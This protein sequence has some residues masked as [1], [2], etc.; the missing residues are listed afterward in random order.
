MTFHDLHGNMGPE[1]AIHRAGNFAQRGRTS[2]P[3]GIRPMGI[4]RAPELESA[5][6]PK[7]ICISCVVQHCTPVQCKSLSK[8]GQSVHGL[9]AT[10]GGSRP[11]TSE[12][13]ASHGQSPGPTGQSC[14]DAITGDRARPHALR[15]TRYS[16]VQGLHA[17]QRHRPGRLTSSRETC[18]LTVVDRA[19]S[20]C[21]MRRAMYDGLHP[22]FCALDGCPTCPL[23]C[24]LSPE[25]H[26]RLGSSIPSDRAIALRRRYLVS[27]GLLS[28]PRELNRLY[29]RSES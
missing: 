25:S 16:G 4:S 3:E 11:V 19:A 2:R 1:C 7:C 17:A 5:T 13:S 28:A 14:G 24:P 21:C 18:E 22:A 12:Q 27:V 8:Y 20:W 9:E 23:P 10:S 29:R 6:L 15:N 26:H